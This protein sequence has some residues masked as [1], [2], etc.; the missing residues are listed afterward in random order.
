MAH[1][2]LDY[3]ILKSTYND[4]EGQGIN[5]SFSVNDTLK[6]SWISL[7]QNSTHL[8]FTG[9]PDNSQTG[10]I[11]LT[12]KAEDTNPGVGFVTDDIIV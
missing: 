2:G 4:P 6:G 12:V 7:A 8:H 11:L 9:T 10:N 1:Y 5:Y 3:S